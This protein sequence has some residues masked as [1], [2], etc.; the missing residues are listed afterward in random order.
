[1]S[2]KILYFEA[3]TFAVCRVYSSTIHSYP[4]D[5]S[6]Y[7]SM[8]SSTQ[9]HRRRHK[10][11]TQQCLPTL[12]PRSVVK[13]RNDESSTSAHSTIIIILA[14]HSRLFLPSFSSSKLMASNIPLYFQF[15]P[16]EFQ[17]IPARPISVLPFNNPA[18]LILRGP[19]RWW[20]RFRHTNLSLITKILLSE[21]PWCAPAA[22]LLTCLLAYFANALVHT[23][24]LTKMGVMDVVES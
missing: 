5:V 1:M 6:N 17:H 7:P 21:F 20:I 18:P 22:P 4:L 19:V 16:V 9:Y 10:K 24:P 2:R 15:S 13:H 3:K 11:S 23:S 12:T 14:L 8:I